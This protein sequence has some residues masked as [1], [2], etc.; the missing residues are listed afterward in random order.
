MVN[1]Y[2][3]PEAR[4]LARNESARKYRNKDIEKHR[5]RIK[6][7]RNKN[8]THVRHRSLLDNC[9]DRAQKKGLE[10]SLT[11][12]DIIIPEFC[13]I[14]GIKLEAGFDKSRDNSPS[15]D[16]I[17]LDKG[18]TPDN[19]QVISYLANRMKNNATLEQIILLGKWAEN[20]LREK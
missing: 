13:P 2:P 8:L 16:R 14:L 17:F 11:L 6:E 19:I 7:W 18:Y 5:E 9:R 3:T 15:V 10:Y 4:R 1:R 20:K 12:E